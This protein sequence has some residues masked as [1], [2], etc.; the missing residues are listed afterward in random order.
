MVILQAS[1]R[2]YR[3][4]NRN[5]ER[6]AKLVEMQSIDSQRKAKGSSRLLYNVLHKLGFYMSNNM[7]VLQQSA[8]KSSC[9]GSFNMPRQSSGSM[10][11]GDN[12]S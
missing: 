9:L 12:K 8:L 5:A 10:Y 4:C 2:R 7:L 3:A 6:N 1:V 11:I